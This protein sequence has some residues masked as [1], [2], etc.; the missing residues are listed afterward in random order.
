MKPDSDRPDPVRDLW[1]ELRA[2]LLVYG[3]LVLV[4]LLTG[5]ACQS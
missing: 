4:P 2:L 5:F 1:A 3:A